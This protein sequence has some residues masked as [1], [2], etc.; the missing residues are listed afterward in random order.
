VTNI[1]GDR[2][3][4]AGGPAPAP[5]RP[6]RPSAA[7]P[8]H[9]RRSTR[10][11]AV[12]DRRNSHCS[13]PICPRGLAARCA[14]GHGV[15]GY[16]PTAGSR[17]SSRAV[18]GQDQVRTTRNRCRTARGPRGR[19]PRST[20]RC[21]TDCGRPTAAGADGASE[22]LGTG[23]VPGGRGV[24]RDEPEPHWARAG[25]QLLDPDVGP[26]GVGRGPVFAAGDD[27]PGGTDQVQ[28]G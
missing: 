10:L 27:H 22:V 4:A 3:T 19:A 25:D 6:R 12:I 28:L 23:V 26:S 18:G 7:A 1:H 20:I 2:L 21:P 17:I 14:T 16:Q 15:E 9:C 11:V 8:D 24:K 5:N 13:A